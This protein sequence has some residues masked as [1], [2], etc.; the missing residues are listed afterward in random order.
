MVPQ[1]NIHYFC[2]IVC[3]CFLY[4]NK[5]K[6]SKV[7]NSFPLHK[8]WAVTSPGGPLVSHSRRHPVFLVAP[9]YHGFSAHPQHAQRETL[10]DTW[11]CIK[12]SKLSPCHVGWHDP[13]IQQQSDNVETVWGD[14]NILEV[15]WTKTAFLAKQ[16]SPNH[17][18]TFPNHR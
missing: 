7:W 11:M 15:L 5:V 17:N 9:K 18:P 6:R 12:W 4:C 10:G 1:I 2:Y 3:S 8:T 14:M 16:W 13:K